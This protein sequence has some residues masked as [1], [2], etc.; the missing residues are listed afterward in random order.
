M[1]HLLAG[2][3]R[4]TPP[5]AHEPRRRL[6]SNSDNRMRYPALP[7]GMFGQVVPLCEQDDVTSKN[8]RVHA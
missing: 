4:A 8:C 6:G 3:R 7:N 2:R 1:W 5:A